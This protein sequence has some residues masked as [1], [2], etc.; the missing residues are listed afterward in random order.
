MAGL[1]VL[2]ALA[3]YWP[4]TQ[5]DFV[6][7][8]DSDFLTENPHVQ[9][10][11]NWA[12]VKWAFCNT[13][14]ATYWAPLMWL[15]HMLAWQL[16]GMN[17]WGHHLVNVLLHATNT[18]L[19]FLVFRRLTGATWRSLML[20]ALFGVHPLQVE[21][22]AWVT[23]RKDVLSGFFGLL[24]LLAYVR[25]AELS[26]VGDP[27]SVIRNSSLGVRARDNG[28]RALHRRSLI[29][30][31]RLR[32]YVLSLF[33]FALGLMSKPM[34]ATLPCV[35]LLVDYWPLGRMQNA[36]CRMQNGE[37]RLTPQSQ[38]A[39]RK[40]KMFFLLFVEKLPFFALAAVVSV[41]TFLAQKRGGV[42]VMTETLT[43]GARLG[44][45]LISY[46][47][48]LEKLFWPRDLSIPYLYPGHWPLGQVLLAGGGLLGLT[49][50]FWMRR[51][52]YPYWLMG[53]LWFGGMLVPVIQLAQ[54][55]GVAMADRFTYLPSLGMLLAAIWGA[56][57][58]T[59]GWQYRV[60]ALS[61]AGGSAIVFCLLLTRQQIGY[62]RD[63]EVLFRHA[64][65]VTRNNWVA[66]N[67]LGTALVRKGQTDEAICH[68][69]EAIR[70]K[71]DRPLFH[72]N[73]GFAFGRKGQM[74]DAIRE[75][76]EALRL[77]PGD[78]AAHYNLGVAFYQQHRTDEAIREFQDALRLKPDFAAARQNLDVALAARTRPSPPHG[79]AARP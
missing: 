9:G 48:Y 29:T 78:A 72:Y 21:S 31:H 39:N 52:R 69:Q 68:Y 53:W 27:W 66:H 5:C 37:S 63:S 23:E 12:G 15:S 54:A 16:F 26:V 22:V 43:L 36:E 34:V 75:F 55:G 47:G 30:D 18:T 57:E 59:R 77:K 42:S 65:A 60:V 13:E 45:A 25:Y 17:A 10:G 1:L 61:V 33:C 19:V 41:V 51:G 3:L 71:P 44:N 4:A 79:G 24:A 76:Q 38:I 73:L 28:Q 20:A 56:Y 11:L 58:F 46:R 50:M 14:R 32:F 64:L 35:L 67:S 2:V 8:D 62:W 49:V 40:S 70:L 6:N 74:D 7:Y